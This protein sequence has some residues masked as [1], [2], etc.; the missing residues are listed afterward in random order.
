M[1]GPDGDRDGRD[2]GLAALAGALMRFTPEL[3]LADESVILMEVTASLRLFGGIRALRSQVRRIVARACGGEPE[4][5]PVLAVAACGPAAWMLARSGRGGSAL[6]VRSLARALAQVPLDVAPPARP[7]AEWFQEL[8]CATLAD[9]RRLPRVGLKKRCG[10]ALLDWLDRL[11]NVPARYRW[12][13]PPPAFDAA[14]EM[15]DHIEHAPALSWAVQHLVR[16]LC[17]WLAARQL[18][19]E[20]LTVLLG[21]DRIRP[22]GAG[23]GQSAP[24][25]RSAAAAMPA[26]MPPGHLPQ[27]RTTALDI[28]LGAPSRDPESLARLVRERLNRLVLPAS[29]IT[30]RLRATQLRAAQAPSLEL[31]PEPG[32]APRDHARLL[33]LLAARLGAENVLVPAPVADHRPEQAARWAPLDPRGAGAR[34][35]ET[36]GALPRPAWLLDA[37]IPLAVRGH[38]PFHGTPLRLVSPAER[39]DCGWQDGGPVV[40]D[41]FVAEDEAGACYWI[42]RSAGS[43]AEKGSDAGPTLQ[44]Y[45]HGLFA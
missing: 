27:G 40:R 24:A 2:A 3:T 7:F 8:G 17:A 6:G 15:P 23:A 28:G 9:L 12:L 45:L 20:A 16:Q 39:L 13:T 26:A 21:H 30:V 33:E 41:Y 22:D 32:G 31:F 5:P 18:D 25:G 34:A 1:P 37:P 38:R 4:S 43:G 29:V 10:P 11:D 19:A 42:F 44:W 35:K 14:L 36:P